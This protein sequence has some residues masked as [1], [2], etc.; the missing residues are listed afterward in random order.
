MHRRFP[1]RSLQFACLW[2]LLWVV[3]AGTAQATPMLSIALDP[4]PPTEIGVGALL[5]V[6]V[7]AE[8][9]PAPGLFG[10]GFR[11]V[12]D[13]AIFTAAAPVIDPFWTGLTDVVVG[14]GFAGASANLS[15]GGAGSGPTGFGI[16]LA[17]IELTVIASPGGAMTPT[18]LSLA[19]LTGEGDNLLFDGVPLDDPGSPDFL[20]DS[21]EAVV[22]EARIVPLLLSAT[23]GLLAARSRLRAR[24]HRA[25]GYGSTPSRW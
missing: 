8:D 12:F 3:G 7:A 19:P 16:P 14:V 22:P 10:F 15:G 21:V 20:A 17:V 25:L 1:A 11:L 18:Q 23:V 4:A 13:P 2:P 5:E 9:I 24:P 6:T